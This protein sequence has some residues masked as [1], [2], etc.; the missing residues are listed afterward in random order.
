[1]LVWSDDGENH[2][3]DDGGGGTYSFHRIGRTV[4]AD[5]RTLGAAMRN[6]SCSSD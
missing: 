6:G 4:S 2:D 3:D 5:R 1:M